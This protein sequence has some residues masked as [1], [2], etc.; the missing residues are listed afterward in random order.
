MREAF[1]DHQNKNSEILQQNQKN[2]FYLKGLMN[3]QTITSK[4]RKE[5]SQQ[6]L[7]E[8]S[9]TTKQQLN[10]KFG[11]RHASQVV[12]ETKTESNTKLPPLT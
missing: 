6:I 9:K 11:R 7:N 10:N 2:S 3:K 5:A 1:V 12:M 4:L 8:F